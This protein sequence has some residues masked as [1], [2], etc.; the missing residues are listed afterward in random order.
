[1]ASAAAPLLL[2]ALVGALVA[3]R[4]ET[5]LVCL[6]VAALAA[7]R[8]Q[9]PRISGR[10]WRVVLVS[11]VLAFVLNLYL[12]PGRAL[13]GPRI[14][15]WAPTAEGARL[16]LLFA[17]RL[18]GAAVALHGLRAAWP[19]ERAADEIARRMMPLEKLRVPVRDARAMVGLAV[20]FAP[21]LA[22]EA[23]RIARLQTLRAGRAPRTVFEWLERKRAVTVPVFVHA[24]ERAEQV[25]LALEA[26]HYRTRPLPPGTPSGWGWRGAGLVLAGASLV[27]RGR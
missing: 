11:V 2:G 3:G 15:R 16:G 22:D 9:A 5:G 24:L 7:W 26:R 25:A 13:P 8:V 18:T 12:D 20:R 14:G 19:G 6:M 10:W 1:V 23:E 17:L 4:W 27:W 21:L